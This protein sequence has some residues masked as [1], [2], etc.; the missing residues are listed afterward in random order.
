MGS[1]SQ[2][3]NLPDMGLGGWASL[4]PTGGHPGY[5]GTNGSGYAIAA[6]TVQGSTARLLSLEGTVQNDTPSKW[7]RAP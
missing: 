1:H 2:N 6:Y 3:P 7:E 4:T 5:F